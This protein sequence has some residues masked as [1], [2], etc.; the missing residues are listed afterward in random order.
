MLGSIYIG[1]SGMDAYSRGLKV[2]SNNVANLNTP[3]FKAASPQFQDLYD[4]QGGVR[5]FLGGSF[6][7][8]DGRG[9]KIG[10]SLTD[11]KQGD[12]VQTSNDLDLAIQGRGFLVLMNDGKQF[13]SR[14]GQF[15]IDKDGYVAEQGTGYKLGI[16]D[17]GGNAVPINIEDKRINDPVATTKVTFAG[18]L[19]AT[20]GAATNEDVISDIAVYDSRGQKHVW[21]VTLTRNDTFHDQW[22]IAVA[23]SNG[24][25]PDGGLN[26]F[27]RFVGGS[28]DPSAQE[29]TFTEMPEGA[30]QLSVVLDFSQ[31]RSDFG[32]STLATSSVDGT[33]MGNLTTVTVDDTGQIVLNYS[34]SKTEK[35]GAVAVADF[36][37]QQG[38]TQ[39]GNGLFENS[40]NSE[41][42]LTA[43]DVDG[44]GK[45]ISKRLESSN[46]DLSAE[47]GDLILIQRGF[48]ACS[49]VV[50]V[51]NDMIQQLFGIRGQA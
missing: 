31:S 48:Q 30:D 50:S 49:Q 32:G 6:I 38:L 40:G 43:S 41:M 18:N 1:L 24:S 33:G 51:S 15:A 2:I 36:R 42:S 4:A 27:I 29:V 8:T 13:Y 9:V 14:T 46:V 45:V 5:G 17:S 28:S 39:Q 34:N 35:E 7:G 26:P 11:F 19:N 10:T 3:G 20:V 25:H 23:D 44:V 21:T 47:F 37:D 12:L 16:L 22:S